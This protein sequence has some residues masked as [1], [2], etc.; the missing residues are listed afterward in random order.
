MD[1]NH[2][3]SL[4]P[5]IED[6]VWETKVNLDVF[7]SES[8]AESYQRVVLQLQRCLAI[9]A[10]RDPKATDPFVIDVDGPVETFIWEN[11]VELS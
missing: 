9:K 1:E 5:R 11:H 3:N 10:N 4:K 7:T 8:D 6:L 2:E